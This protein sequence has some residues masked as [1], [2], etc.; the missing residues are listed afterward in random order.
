MTGK[1]KQSISHSIHWNLK[2]TTN[3]TEGT[4]TT[5]FP[6]PNSLIPEEKHRI[7]LRHKKKQTF[8]HPAHWYLKKNIKSNKRQGKSQS[9]PH[10]INRRPKKITKNFIINKRK[11][12]KRQLN[13]DKLRRNPRDGRSAR[14][15]PTYWKRQIELTC[16][17]GGDWV[18]PVISLISSLPLPPSRGWCEDTLISPHRS[19]T[20]R[21]KNK[22]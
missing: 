13:V 6:T 1:K 19:A 22:H 5:T 15:N 8:P 20:I 9:S 17:Y 11:S 3:P 21:G 7:E 14:R 2:T 10:S 4:P 18:A 16:R 12:K